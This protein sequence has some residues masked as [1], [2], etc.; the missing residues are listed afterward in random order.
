[1]R[2]LNV[3]VSVQTTPAGTP[4]AFEY[5]GRKYRVS[6]IADRWRYTGRWWA[7]GRGYFGGLRGTGCFSCRMMSRRRSGGCIGYMISWHRHQSSSAV[8]AMSSPAMYTSKR[9]ALM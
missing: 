7:E 3:P 2:L 5:R 9:R 8:P 4:T 6:A 1:M